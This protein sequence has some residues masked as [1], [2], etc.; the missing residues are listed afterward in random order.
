MKLKVLKIKPKTRVPVPTEEPTNMNTIAD[1]WIHTLSR[2]GLIYPS[3]NLIQWVVSCE[4]TFVE[5]FS[6]DS[7]SNIPQISVVVKDRIMK[8][9][10]LIDPLVV[11]LYV[12]TRLKIRLKYINTLKSKKKRRISK[13]N[14]VRLP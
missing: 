13:K 8:L 14:K 5:S 4:K 11:K 10:P 7:L 6:L 3:P 12:R 1:L 2:G 9:N